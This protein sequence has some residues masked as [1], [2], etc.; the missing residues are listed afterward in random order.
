MLLLVLIVIC[1]ELSNFIPKN[2]NENGFITW[3]DHLP[4]KCVDRMVRMIIID[5]IINTRIVEM[6]Y[7]EKWCILISIQ[8]YYFTIASYHRL[9][10][11]N[12]F[13]HLWS[14][15]GI[16]FTHLYLQKSQRIQNLQ[17]YGNNICNTTI[18][19]IG[20]KFGH[21]R[22]DYNDTAL[23]FPLVLSKLND[24]RYITGRWHQ[25]TSF[26]G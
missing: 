3:M 9:I 17:K 1:I 14:I 24:L 16:I 5:V 8:V 19:R 25:N 26:L 11:H 12:N 13:I 22:Q 10:K 7:K 21:F 2:W 15:Y 4:N 20:V 23:S 6:G 18:G